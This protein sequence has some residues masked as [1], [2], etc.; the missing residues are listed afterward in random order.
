MEVVKVYSPVEDMNIRSNL[1]DSLIWTLAYNESELSDAKKNHS[2]LYE[3]LIKF[4]GLKPVM[5]NKI[6]KI[7]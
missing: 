3:Y 1:K 6:T 5:V 7:Q 2:E 4:D